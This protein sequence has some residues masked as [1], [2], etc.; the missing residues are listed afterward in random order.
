MQTNE[1]APE[2][3]RRLA[4]LKP[5]EGRVLSVYLNLD[6]SEFATPQARATQITSLLDEADA[7]VARAGLDLPEE[8]EA[9]ELGPL[10]AA[11]RLPVPATAA[12][13]PAPSTWRRL[14]SHDDV[15]WGP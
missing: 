10:P 14:A 1:I 4:P 3:L 9:R 7:Y 6:P 15:I 11:D 8:P 5:A 12:A 13:G 2:R